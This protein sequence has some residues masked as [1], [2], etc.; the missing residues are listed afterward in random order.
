M[1]FLHAAIHPRD[2]NEGDQG[3]ECNGVIDELI[4]NRKNINAG[5]CC[6]EHDGNDGHGN[7]R[8]E[9]SRDAT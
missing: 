6:E 3:I 5:G 2:Q 9:H 8:N 4:D 7:A 1:Q